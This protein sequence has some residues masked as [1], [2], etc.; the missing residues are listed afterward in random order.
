MEVLADVGGQLYGCPGREDP[1]AVFC[2]EQSYRIERNLEDGSWVMTVKLPY[3]TADELSVTKEERGLL[4]GVRNET[5]R[6]RLIDKCSRRKL[7]GWKDE[8]GQLVITIA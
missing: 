8:E 3:M 5:R 6:F 7:V 4:L 1:T 2:T